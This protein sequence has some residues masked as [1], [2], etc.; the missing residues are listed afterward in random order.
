MC[1][2]RVLLSGT[3]CGA[4]FKQELESL[5]GTSGMSAQDSCRTASCS[6]HWD[7]HKPVGF[8]SAHRRCSGTQQNTKFPVKT[9]KKRHCALYTVLSPK[10]VG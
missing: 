10:S 4:D 7:M 1:A 5:P 8:Q 3:Q 6:P 2:G 9:H